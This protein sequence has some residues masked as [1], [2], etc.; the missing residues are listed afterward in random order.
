[1]FLSSFVDQSFLFK[2]HHRLNTYS[3]EDLSRVLSSNNRHVL[4]IELAAKRVQINFV[5]TLAFD[6]PTVIATTWRTGNTNTSLEALAQAADLPR[7][8]R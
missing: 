7:R 4:T 2:L 1:M 5:E 3:L 6:R 8:V